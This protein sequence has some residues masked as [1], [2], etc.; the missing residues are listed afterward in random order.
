[1]PIL[2]QLVDDVVV[3]KF[4]LKQGEITIGR[5]PDNDIIIDD[6]SVSG[7]H[8][9]IEVEKSQYFDGALEY[10]IIDKDSKNGTTVNDK[11]V[12]GRER[13]VNGDIVRIAWNQFKLIDDTGG[14]LA[15]T[16]HVLQ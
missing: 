4:D 13:L 9:V 15:S 3:T 6:I 2:A 8:A 1:M 7:H 11:P 16:A 10:F 14:E 12:T 5:H